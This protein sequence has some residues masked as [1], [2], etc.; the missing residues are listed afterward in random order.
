ML[1]TKLTY[2]L[3]TVGLTALAA[4]FLAAAPAGTGRVQTGEENLSSLSEKTFTKPSEDIPLDFSAP[5]LVTEVKVKE[6]DVVKAGQVL[7]IQDVSVETANKT[8]YEIEA[9]SDV[10]EVY[11]QKDRDVKEVK[12]LRMQKLQQQQNATEL[13]VK[14]AQL[15]MERAEASV[16]LAR[17]KR[18]VAR[19]Q[20][21]IE[22]AKIKLKQIKSPVDGVVQKLD[23]HVG[24]V[25]KNEQN[26]PAIRV[27]RNDVLWID[28]H[29]PA[30]AVNKLKKGQTLQVRYATEDKW[31]PAE[32]LY[33]QPVVRYGSQ[34][35]QVRLQ[36]AN[37][38]DRPAGLEVFVK[39]PDGSV[40]A[41]DDA[42]GQPRAVADR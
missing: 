37:T 19:A 12:F 42:A 8:M 7:A 4:G 22:E 35:R 5:G 31:M 23:T 1:K 33:L 29:L 2:V 21:N 40:A 34:T 38:D 11:A 39:L 20:A 3:S 32:I 15:E 18:D 24:E 30:A 36:L 10:E 41:G 13:E 16:K 27:V 17:Q 26:K 28:A 25:A 6:G 14:E 9:N